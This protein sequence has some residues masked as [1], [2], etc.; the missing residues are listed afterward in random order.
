MVKTMVG[1]AGGGD[2]GPPREGEGGNTS[3]RGSA[4][5]VEPKRFSRGGEVSDLRQHGVAGPIGP[6][7]V[8]VS[9]WLGDT[10]Q[11]A[12]RHVS[13]MTMRSH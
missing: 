13:L 5:P 4:R 10:R 2:R 11:H 6:K 1:V 3:N 12:R 9:D 7:Q 8:A